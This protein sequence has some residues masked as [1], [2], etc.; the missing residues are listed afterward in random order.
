[1]SLIG[2]IQVQSF[3]RTATSLVPALF[4]PNLLEGISADQL[5]SRG[6]EDSFLRDLFVDLDKNFR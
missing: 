3:R 4:G 2:L 1:M 5:R 6:T